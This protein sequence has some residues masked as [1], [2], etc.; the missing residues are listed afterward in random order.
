MA[1]SQHACSCRSFSSSLPSGSAGTNLRAYLPTVGGGGG[2]ESHEESDRLHHGC[3]EGSVG[4]GGG[5]VH[6]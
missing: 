3:R 5:C 2:G 4:V 6:G 1:L